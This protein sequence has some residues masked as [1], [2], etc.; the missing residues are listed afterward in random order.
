MGTEEEQL[1]TTVWAVGSL[2]GG[3]VCMLV[4]ARAAGCALL[5]SL[6]GA[7]IGFLVVAGDYDM[8]P[9]G[10]I[11]GATI[12]VLLG[13]VFGLMWGPDASRSILVALGVI[14]G[15]AG[16]AGLVF[17]T[18]GQSGALRCHPRRQQMCFP[19]LDGWATV[20]FALDAMWVAFVCFFQAAQVTRA[21]Q[22]RSLA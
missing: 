8:V 13:G 2:V 12:G 14:A 18:L 20:V 5:G 22:Q 19:D 1:I 7:F 11:V 3:L 9:M 10:M 4:G 16:L 6:L 21:G 15:F 17:L